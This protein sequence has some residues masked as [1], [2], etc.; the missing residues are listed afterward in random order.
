MKRELTSWRMLEPPA[1]DA[2]HR[3]A[4]FAAIRLNALGSLFYFSKYVLNRARLSNTLHWNIAKTLEKEHLHLVLQIPRDHLKTTLVTESL[5][6]WWSLNFTE[7]DE[8]MMRELGYGDAWIRWMKHAHDVNNRTLIVS[9]NEPN[10]IRF[11]HRIDSHYQSNAMFRS[12][13]K[14]VLPDGSSTWNDRTKTQKRTASG[15]GEGTFDFLGVGGA[16]QSRHYKRIIQDDIFG[17]DAKNSELVANDTIEYHRLLGGVFDHEASETE[18]GDEVVVGNRW[19]YYDLNGWIIENNTQGKWKIETHDAEGGCCP[20]HPA[21]IPIFLS[22]ELLDQMKLRYSVEDF[23]H[24]FKNLAVIPGE[25]PFR[26][27]WLRYY[28]LYEGNRNGLKAAYIR[29]NIYSG[30]ALGDIPVS[31]LSRKMVVDPNHSESSGRANHGIAVVGFDTESGNQYLLDTWAKSTS[32][33]ELV[34]KV[35]EFA[36]RWRLN[37]VYL[38]KIA[39]QQLLRYPLEYHGKRKGINLVLQYINAPRSKNAKDERIRALEPIFRNSKLWTRSDQKQFEGEYRTYPASRTLDILDTMSYANNLFDSVRYKDA[40]AVVQ[41][42]NS[43]RKAAMARN[44]S[45]EG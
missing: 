26:P 18:L 13:F 42:W 45:T 33:D 28:E 1:N 3:E 20:D 17:R 38:E 35:Y 23:S 5:S 31:I 4:H 8:A 21:G 15:I 25:A 36:V 37:E 14:D 11:G 9:E 16:V 44:T 27:E 2:K 29:H 40:V 6:I 32:Y 43:R 30:K 24:Q 7:S 10:A 19:G 22:Q 39:A 41:N 34:S 12:I